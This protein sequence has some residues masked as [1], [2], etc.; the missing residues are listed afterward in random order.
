MRTMKYAPVAALGLIL[1]ACGGGGG[2]GDPAP[3]PNT[4][5]PGNGQGSGAPAAGRVTS[6]NAKPLAALGFG[7]SE[8]G[9]SVG[10]TA[11]AGSG[12][13]SAVGSP[14]FPAA[15]VRAVIVSDPLVCGL[16]SL[17]GS[18]SIT[19][20]QDDRDNSGT[21][22]AGDV[23]TITFSECAFPGDDETTSGAM[24]F[25]FVT[26]TGDLAGD[27]PY[28][29]TGNATLQNMASRYAD[30]SVETINGLV[31]LDVQN[32]DGITERTKST[33]DG[34]TSTGT[35]AGTVVLR[36]FQFD[37]TENL[38]TFSSVESAKGTIESSVHGTFQL[39]QIEPWQYFNGADTPS[40]G[41]AKLTG[42]DNTSVT[43]QAIDETIAR[44]LVDS[45]GDGTA[46]DTIDTT[47]AELNDLL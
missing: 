37:S 10:G 35:D 44:L 9:N 32:S 39:A 16:P 38:S 12:G 27:G 43:V 8:V 47:W 26:L 36:N 40:S 42:A 22:S 21:P 18:G 31:S 13:G 6:Q 25:E 5:G 41:S 45:N 4:N 2:G 19:I 14:A 11:K 23:L 15:S 33:T 46:D 3:A 28:A 34:L 24:R 20:S 1:V 17:G 7:T 29:Y 30:G